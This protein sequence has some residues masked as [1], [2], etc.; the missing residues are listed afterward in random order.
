[1]NLKIEFKKGDI[2]KIAREDRDL[3]PMGVR[4]GDYA[5]VTSGNHAV[6]GRKWINFVYAD[7]KRDSCFP[8]MVDLIW[9][10]E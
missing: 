3:V 7:G 6:W 9:R 4:M 8:Y 1:M 10:D 5:K 2:V